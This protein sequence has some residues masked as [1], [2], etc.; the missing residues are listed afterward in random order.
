VPYT[1]DP[2]K[3]RAD[4]AYVDRLFSRTQEIEHASTLFFFLK[5][6]TR[7]TRTV[8]AFNESQDS[9]SENWD[10]ISPPSRSK[11][12]AVVGD[13]NEKSKESGN[14]GIRSQFLKYMEQF[15]EFS[16]PISNSQ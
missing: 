2:E 13:L 12:E 9:E 7:H 8:I 11:I 4:A 3:I 15:S 5:E 10:Y 14:E 16:N 1:N 6:I